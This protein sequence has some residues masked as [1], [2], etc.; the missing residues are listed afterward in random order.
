MLLVKSITL[1]SNLNMWIKAQK[2]AY[3]GRAVLGRG[4]LKIMI[5]DVPAK[6]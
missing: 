5:I 4:F 3:L 1:F 2:P 6:Q